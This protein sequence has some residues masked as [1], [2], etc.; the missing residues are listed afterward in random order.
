MEEII[1]ENVNP[2]LDEPLN[3]EKDDF[4]EDNKFDFSG[5]DVINNKKEEKEK[6][7]ND[8]DKINKKKLKIFK[9]FL[10]KKNKNSL[11][12]IFIS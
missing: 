2:E 4:E 10:L 5:Y 11:S 6:N 1:P 8:F 7:N 9:I 3:D 12:I